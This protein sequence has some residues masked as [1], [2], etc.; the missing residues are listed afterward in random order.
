MILQRTAS[1]KKSSPI[2]YFK[3]FEENINNLKYEV[4]T[5]NGWENYSS[6][7]NI[8][9]TQSNKNEKKKLLKRMT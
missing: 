8:S 3:K 1:L 5:F 7:I 2:A 4:E 9:S 6:A